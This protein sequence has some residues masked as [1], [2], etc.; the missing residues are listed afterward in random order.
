MTITNDSV[1]SPAQQRLWFLNRFQEGAAGHTHTVAL[2]LAGGLGPEQL[3]AA[4]DALVRRHPLLGTVH[5]EAEGR[6]RPEPAPDG[7]AFAG[8]RPEPVAPDELDEALT[9]AVG[10]G[11]DLTREPPL[12]ARLLATGPDAHVLVLTVHEIAAD[13]RS[14]AVIVDDLAR[15]YAAATDPAAPGKTEPAPQYAAAAAADR[16]LNG[17]PERPTEHAAAELAHWRATLDG[18]PAQLDLPVDRPRPAVTRYAADEYRG[19][20][21]GPLAAALADLAADCGAGVEAV[22]HAAVVA[23]LGR[24]GAGADVP[25]IGSLPGRDDA[26]RAAVVGPLANPVVLRVVRR[27]GA[28]FRELV[29]DCAAV[30]DTARRHGG[31]PFETVVGELRPERALNRHPLAQVA[32]DLAEDLPARLDFGPLDAQVAQL[33]RQQSPFDLQLRF[34]SAPDGSGLRLAATFSTELFD[35]ATV[36]R[37]TDALPRLLAAVVA[38]PDADPDGYEVLDPAERHAL[39]TAW[40]ATDRPV[41]DADVS[42]LFRARAAAQPARTALIAGDTVLSYAELDDRAERLAGELRRHGAAP[43]RLVALALPRSADLVVALLAV[44]RTG[45]AYVPLDP[46]YPA[47]RIG[48]ILDHAAPSALVT[49]SATAGRLPATAAHRVLLD[50]EEVRAR[51]ATEPAGP[52]GPAATAADPAYVIYTSGS[53]GRPKGVVISRHALTNFLVSMADLFPLAAEDVWT[54]VTTIAFDIAAL[55]IY[56]PLVGGATVVLAD[57]ATVTDPAGLGAL[58]GR[59]GTTIMQATPSLW[60]ALCDEVPQ[61]L[62]GL[63]MLVGGEALPTALAERMRALGSEVTNLYGPTE[64]TIWSTAARLDD[65]PG[66]PTIGRPIGNTRVRVLDEALRL[67]PIGAAG[68]LY[69]AGDGVGTGYLHRED[70]TRDRFLPDP[71][72]AEGE[73]MYRTGDIV[74]WAADGN[75]EYVGRADFQLKVRGFRI[76]PGEIDAVLEQHPAVAR[77]VTVAREYAAGD[78][79][80]VSYVVPAGEGGADPAGLRAHAAATLPGYMVPAVVVPIP[81]IPLTP[82]GKTDRAALP[83]PGTA[84]TGSGHGPRSAREEQLCDLFC[85]VLGVAS[86]G[87]DDSFFDLGGHSLLAT[88]LIGRIRS[89]LDVE[90]PIRTLFESPTVAGLAGRLG[91]EPARRAGLVPVDRD[92]PLPLSYGQQRLWFLY[93]YES[94]GTEY[95][96]PLGLRLTGPL[97]RD[98]LGRAVDAL[99]ARHEA[100]RT[101]FATE[102]GQGV[103]VVHAPAHRPV[104]F[105]DLAAEGRVDDL[106]QLLRTELSRSFDLRGG[107]LLRPWLIRLADA[108]HL[109][110]LDMHHVVTDGWSKEVMARELVALLGQEATGRP[111][112]LSEL[113][114]QYADFAVHQHGERGAREA[115][116]LD[117]WK[118]RLDGVVPLELPTDRP[119]P[120]TRATRGAGHSFELSPELVAALTRLCRREGV[121]LFTVLTAGVQLLL[122]RYARQ[123]DVAVGT[124]VSGREH[125]ELEDVLGFFVNTLV[126]R[127]RTAPDTTVGAFLADVRQ[128]VLEA[129]THQ[130]LPY[131]RLIDELKP[132]RDPSRTPLIQAALMLKRAQDT[133]P[134]PD[135]LRV[136]ESALPRMHALFDIGFEFEERDGRLGGLVEY[137]TALFD[138]ETVARIARHLTVLLEGMAAADPDRLVDELPLM[139]E[140]ERRL[141][142]TGWNA[143]ATGARFHT[144]TVHGLVADQAR[145]TPD[146]AAVTTEDR[147]LTFAE[148]DALTDALAHRLAD[149]GVG[150]GTVVGVR[151]RRAAEMTIAQLAVLKA[152]GAYLPLDPELPDDRTVY[153]LQDAGVPVLLTQRD[154]PGPEAPDGVEVLYVEDTGPGTHDGPPEVAVG[155]SDLAYVIY[156]SGS[157][158]KAKGVLIEHRGVVNLCDWY[159]DFFDA[160]PGDRATQM[161]PPGFDPTVLEQWGA[162][163]CGVEIRFA[164]DRVL[165]DPHLLAAW[166]VEEGITLILIPAPRLEGLLDQPALHQGRVRHILTGADVVRRRLP[167]GSTMALSNLYGPTETTV[168]TTGTVL[169]AEEDAPVGR[170]PSIG[171]PVANTTGYVLD[172]HRVPVP[173]GVPGELYVGGAGVARGY[174]GRP[175]LTEERFVPDHLAATAG[176]RLYR[177]GDLVRWLPDG[178]LEFLGRIDNQ[179]KVRG[180]RIELGEIETALLDDESVEQTAVVARTGPSGQT[181]LTGY[182]VPADGTADPEKIRAR[183]AERLPGYMV[184]PVVIVLDA[185]PMTTSGKID[186]RALPEP[187]EQRPAA[188][189]TAPRDETEA[190]LAGIWAEVL[191]VPVVGAEDNVFDHGANSVLTL[192]VTAR[193]REVFGVGVSARHVFAARTVAAL[194]DQVRKQVLEDV[195]RTP[196]D[197]TTTRGGARG[198]NR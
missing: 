114:L 122:S 103:Q 119:R 182:V 66:A 94:Q 80:L 121:T 110:V 63:R 112:A 154:L 120:A 129:F 171:R 165:E 166:I 191:G 48:Y 183:L 116:D 195:R 137:S 96:S 151:T 26:R 7:G 39:L 190:A 90:V 102:G 189:P 143:T 92:R 76:E 59:T 68:E 136:E 64:T 187:E 179:V 23:L 60:Q 17:A 87:V 2:R 44:A 170:L 150:P 159:R 148:L 146:A 15:A 34:R 107:P 197:R 111:A 180:Y 73:R 28:S 97:D 25:L 84:A 185:F 67:V 61:A 83:D 14:L 86:I 43:G 162:L 12:R 163:A 99:V 37:L 38:A 45:A 75:L 139:D 140:Q 74:R 41:P 50:D 134:G 57:R 31:V 3:R 20:L 77:A 53:T 16:E 153:V 88:R 30:A 24:F 51:L 133:L 105:T 42:A 19:E 46:D 91:S 164:S 176:A 178:T 131:D 1:L 62:G 117:Y 81:E 100:L 156:T 196:A 6:C 18:A 160:G 157:T 135:G 10:Q 115:A 188:E 8:L 11:L 128:G 149:R 22:L 55:E 40:N 126:L 56:L 138:P 69:I 93:D 132:D 184:P 95:N 177:T 141:V 54:S 65:R 113:P 124:I 27:P 155:P 198:S 145:R 147:S 49:D 152:G 118:R 35:P 175:E 144:A 72:G 70:L 32:F 108:E 71:Y 161:V 36:R 169:E 4:L 33:P 127:A 58:V 142:T 21:D 106:D 13:E 78:T 9:R 52:Q 192:Q 98:A 130:H 193:I 167:R 29:G 123:R 158:G 174:L 125:S 194:A 89:V 186:R 109:L 181:A 79:R 85:E 173:V 168:L 104:R 101:T 47:D 172:E 82:N 5:R